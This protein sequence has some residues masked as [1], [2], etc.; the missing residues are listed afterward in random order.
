MSASYG[1]RV[2]QRAAEIDLEQRRQA[3]EAAEYQQRCEQRE[4]D[5]ETGHQAR[6]ARER[7]HSG[8]SP[9]EIWGKGSPEAR[10]CRDFLDFMKD[11]DFPG[12]KTL[13][14]E[15][16]TPPSPS[17]PKRRWL[18]R[19][20]VEPVKEL[21]AAEEGWST[22][23]YGIG[24][25]IKPEWSHYKRRE[26]DFKTYPYQPLEHQDIF[27][28]EDGLVRQASGGKIRLISAV[29]YMK[30]DVPREPEIGAVTSAMRHYYGGGSYDVADTNLEEL[31]LQIA[32]HHTKAEAAETD[33]AA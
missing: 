16:D 22:R 18:R 33:S 19:E 20:V 29:N 17:A 6:L 11:H 9:E 2:L 31:L 25:T 26:I 8:Y 13:L 27:L 7:E 3:A 23:G 12:I 1:E 15:P 10:A 32:A 4:R 14:H 5:A 21:A 28:C 30:P 24:F